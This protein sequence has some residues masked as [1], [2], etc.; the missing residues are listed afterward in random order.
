MGLKKSLLK[1]RI[2]KFK[3][4]ALEKWAQT[5]KEYDL[6]I[7]VNVFDSEAEDYG[8]A[9]AQRGLWGAI[10]NII[11]NPVN[12]IIAAVYIVASSIPGLNVASTAAFANWLSSMI[13]TSLAATQ[14]A[15][16]ATNIALN[17]ATLITSA[18]RQNKLLIENIS[19]YGEI[20]GG[21]L[22]QSIESAEV[23]KAKS[24]TLTNTMIYAPY[25]IYPKGAIYEDN[26]LGGQNTNFRYTEP[27]DAMKGINSEY[28]AQNEAEE[29][30][31]NRYQKKDA[32]NIQYMS[33]TL[34]SDLPLASGMDTQRQGLIIDECYKSRVIKTSKGYQKL[35]E[36]GYGLGVGDPNTFDNTWKLLDKATIKPFQSN[37]CDIDFLDKNKAYQKGLMRDFFTQEM[38]HFKTPDVDIK[39]DDNPYLTMYKDLK[40]LLNT[41][42]SDDEK[43][44]FYMDTM[45]RVFEGV[46]FSDKCFVADR[47]AM[48]D[49]PWNISKAYH[50]FYSDDIKANHSYTYYDEQ[51]YR[52]NPNLK[53]YHN[54]FT[55]NKCDYDEIS[56]ERLLALI[57]NAKSLIDLVKT[58]SGGLRIKKYYK[59]I[60]KDMGLVLI[61]EKTEIL[62]DVEVQIYDTTKSEHFIESSSVGATFR[63]SEKNKDLKNP[64]YFI[65][66]NKE[67]ISDLEDK[68]LEKF[69]QDSQNE[70]FLEIP[71]ENETQKNEIDKHLQKHFQ[72]YIT[73][74]FTPENDS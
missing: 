49:K 10:V 33:T 68:S 35:L 38:Y 59:H 27:Y 41:K 57:P 28:K 8:Y 34:N 2:K 36:Q 16:T 52:V 26:Q 73:D 47:S 31:Y 29:M 42:I 64:K 43:A 72:D 13:G 50:F 20:A 18:H 48:Y 44:M 74:L 11:T 56:K 51:A 65:L 25:E 53:Y 61:Y 66:E 37:K 1:K 32:G 45:T 5:I 17:A 24:D 69:L 60:Y 15:L 54:F 67:H 6:R 7:N 46:F 14:T 63:A 21:S 55:L 39:H 70:G 58:F 23:A 22:V 12:V 40:D 19:A 30:S 3:K 71:F 62:N 4:Q 9:M